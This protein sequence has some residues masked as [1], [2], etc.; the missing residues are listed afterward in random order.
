MRILRSITDV[1]TALAPMRARGSIAFV[2]T[3]GALHQGHVSLFRTARVTCQAVA[4]SI[5]VNPTQFNDPADLARYP[6]TEGQDAQLAED[7]GVDVLFAPTREEMYPSG[8]ALSVDVQG[9]ALGFEAAHRPG[10]FSVVATVCLK[11]FTI[12]QQTDVFLG[13]KDAQQVAVLHQL[14]LDANLDL[15][16]RVVPTV[17]DRDGLA[18]SSRNAAL[19]PADRRR[20]LAIPA[21]LSAG[22]AAYQ[23]GDDPVPAARAALAGLD[24]D[25]VA[26]TT[27][28]EHPT[29]VIAVLVGQTRLIDN[30]PLDHPSL[31]GLGSTGHADTPAPAAARPHHA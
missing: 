3:M 5:F 15:T 16:I 10:H 25:Y 19:S 13:Q 8:F 21:A 17:R 11:L 14:V 24:V 28:D 12:V 1:R 23:R 27:F 18:L 2:P 26:V 22:L 20:A 6:R 30:V 29:L 31:A 4:A 9:P 7:A